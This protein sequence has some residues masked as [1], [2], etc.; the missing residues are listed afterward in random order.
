MPLVGVLV[1]AEFTEPPQ[2]ERSAAEWLSKL[3]NYQ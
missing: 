2:I 1:E 3:K